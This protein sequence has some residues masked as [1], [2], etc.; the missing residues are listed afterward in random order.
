M[1]IIF[2]NKKWI[3]EF[4]AEHPMNTAIATASTPSWWCY[5]HNHRLHPHPPSPQFRGN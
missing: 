3:F 4:A 1:I 2:I 5:I